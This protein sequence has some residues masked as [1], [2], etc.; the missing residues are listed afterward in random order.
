[1]AVCSHYKAEHM[2]EPITYHELKELFEEANDNFLSKNKDLFT[3]EV[4]ERTLCGALMV[5]MNGAIKRDF[6]RLNRYKNYF[7]DIEYNRNDGRVKT[8]ID[9]NES[10]VTIVCDLILHSRGRSKWQDNLIAVEMK[11]ST[12][13]SSDKQSD[14]ERLMALT[15]LTDGVWSADGVTLPEHVC[16]YILGVY[17]EINFNDMT[18]LLE[19]YSNGEKQAEHVIHLIR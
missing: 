1:M 6:K 16:G 4:S 14:R 10:I 3:T 9:R 19:Y 8:I 5:S 13:L 11:K 17:Y 12:R 15:R 18:A 7:V 2:R